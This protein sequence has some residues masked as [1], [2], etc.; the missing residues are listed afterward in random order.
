MRY[1]KLHTD[2]RSSLRGSS[3]KNLFL[4]HASRNPNIYKQWRFVIFAKSSVNY[5]Q[6][7][8]STDL[9]SLRLKEVLKRTT[10][11]KY[12]FH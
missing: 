9:L 7:N 12:V 2:E 10:K 6:H 1:S 5:L 3:K 8:S 4:N 11:I